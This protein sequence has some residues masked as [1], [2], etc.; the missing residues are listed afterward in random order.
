MSGRGLDEL[1]T[2]LTAALSALTDKVTATLEQA[3]ENLTV[4][5][6]ATYIAD[7]LRGVRYDAA[8]G[9]FTGDVRL[10]ALTRI[11]P[12]GGAAVVVPS[13][14]AIDQA[15]WMAHSS[16]VERAQAN[17]LELLQTAASIAA[18]LLGAAKPA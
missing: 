10:Q 4:V 11:E 16:M 6:V 8:A 1:R 7:D 14:G 17:R 9:G 18:T 15:I 13:G 3:V 12:N 2:R 5:E